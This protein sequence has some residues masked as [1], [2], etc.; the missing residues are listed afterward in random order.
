MSIKPTKRELSARETKERIIDAAERLFYKFGFETTSVKEVAAEAGVTTG[1]LYYHFKNKGD[2]VRAIFNRH[3]LHF[4]E[5]GKRF[6]TSETPLKDLVYFLSEY[7][8]N[9]VE[10]DGIEF[11][12]QRIFNFFRFDATSGF[13]ATLLIII[14]RGIELNCFKSG[15]TEEELLDCLSAVHRG[16]VYQYCVSA[17]PVDLRKLISQRLHLTLDG[18]ALEK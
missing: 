17:T 8:V 11:T 3:D 2:L 12:R 7:M 14:R 18:V 9:R 4:G 10:A 13:D 1:A 5:L 15:Y 16:A 6:S